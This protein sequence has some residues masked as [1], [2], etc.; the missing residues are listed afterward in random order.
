M[1]TASSIGQM[2]LCCTLWGEWPSGNKE[3]APRIQGARENFE[4]KSRQRNWP[5]LF[6][7][8]LIADG[9]FRVLFTLPFI[10]EGVPKYPSL[11]N[12]L[13]NKTTL[14]L[15][16]QEG[17]LSAAHG[18]FHANDAMANCAIVE[19]VVE[20]IFTQIAASHQ[21]IYPWT[22]GK[23][24]QFQHGV[25]RCLVWPSQLTDPLLSLRVA[26]SSHRHT[27]QMVSALATGGRHFTCGLF[28]RRQ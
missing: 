26:L 22:D 5:V 14:R 15:Q 13:A 16:L 18:R 7:C 25:G 10:F 23:R 12:K 8:E 9:H 2:P 1:Q 20:S 24:K 19:D 27:A 28:L 17:N 4:R 3:A 21:G 6:C 11:T